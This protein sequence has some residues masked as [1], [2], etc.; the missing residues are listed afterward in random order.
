[1]DAGSGWSGRSYDM[2][3]RGVLD[4]VIRRAANT[5]K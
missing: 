3:A 5:D 1:M 4:F 2:G